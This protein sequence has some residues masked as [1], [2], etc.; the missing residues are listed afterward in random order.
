MHQNRMGRGHAE[1]VKIKVSSF[2]IKK[3]KI[4]STHVPLSA[5]VT[6]LPEGEAPSVL[7]T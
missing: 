2:Q 4:A 1:F 5:R 6:A 7:P 3:P